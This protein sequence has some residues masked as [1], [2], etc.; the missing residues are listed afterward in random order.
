MSNLELILHETTVEFPPTPDLVHAVS[1]RIGQS[2]RVPVRRI[3]PIRRSLAIAFASLLLLAGAAVAAVPGLRDPVLDWLGLRS[4]KIER[5]PST[6]KL[7]KRAP[8]DDL[9]LGER[10]SLAAARKQVR[11]APVVPQELGPSTAYVDRF[12]PGGTLSLVYR[13]GKLLLTQFRGRAPRQYL[14]KFVG[15]DVPI[16][17]VDVNGARGIW[18]G[19]ESHGLVYVDANGSL[20]SDSARLAGPTLLWRRGDLLLRLEGARTKAAALRLARSF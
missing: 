19:G 2:R 1:A 20:R 14:R 6:P 8:G 12:V 3:R 15:P 7:P 16:E 10:M 13:N 4:V 5:V 11:F 18:I 9:G 17:R